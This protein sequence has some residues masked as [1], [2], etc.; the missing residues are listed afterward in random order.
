[1]HIL[2]EISISI[3]GFH[4]NLKKEKKCLDNTSSK[5]DFVKKFGDMSLYSIN[6]NLD[7]KNENRITM[8]YASSSKCTVLL[9]I[10]GTLAMK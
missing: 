4:L 9:N 3:L 7:K 2:M 8:K 10:E 1:M 6:D 5:W